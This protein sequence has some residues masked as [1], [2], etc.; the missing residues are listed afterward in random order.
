MKARRTGLRLKY[1]SVE[2]SHGTSL[3]MIVALAEICILNLKIK[4]LLRTRM[5]GTNAGV[6]F[7]KTLGRETA[8]DLAENEPSEVWG[9]HSYPPTSTYPP[10]VPILIKKN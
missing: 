2:F 10:Q 5:K 9:C 3:T 7:P 6:R 1:S 8:V 4:N